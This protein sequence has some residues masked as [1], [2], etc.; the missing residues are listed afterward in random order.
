MGATNKGA[1]SK[2]V[3]AWEA[4]NDQSVKRAAGLGLMAV[5]LAACGSSDDSDDGDDGTDTTPV[6]M[7]A[8]LTIGQDLI[9]AGT[10]TGE[11][12]D[13]ITGAMLQGNGGVTAQSFEDADEIDGGDG[14]DTLT[15][16]IDD[17]VAAM[18]SNVETF[19]VR[20]VSSAV[21]TVDMANFDD[22]LETIT[23]RDSSVGVTIDNIQSAASIALDNVTGNVVVTVA[24]DDDVLGSDEAIA[25]LTVDGSTATVIADVGGE[26]VLTGAIIEVVSDS[27][28]TLSADAASNLETVE[29]VVITGAGDLSLIDAG[30]EFLAITEVDAS[31]LAGGLTMD[32]TSATGPV[33]FTGG[34]GDDDVTASGGA[35]EI[36]TGAGDDTITM[37]A[38]DLTIDAGAG[39]DTVEM[40]G[41]DDADTIDGGAGTN[42][43]SISGANLAAL[44]T[45]IVTDANV[46]NFSVVA[47]TAAMGADVTFNALGTGID[48]FDLTVAAGIAGDDLTLSN[49]NGGTIQFGVNQTG[50]VIVSDVGATDSITLVMDEGAGAT[51]ADV[52]VTSIETVLIV[53]D[54][55]ADDVV[56]TDIDLTGTTSLTISGAGD[57]TFTA[58]TTTALETVDL[59]DA[60]GAITID[61][62]GSDGVEVIVGNVG[63]ST[64]TLDAANVTTD[65]I[66][67]VGGEL[68][69][70]V[71]IDNFEAGI[72]GDVVD[73]SAFGVTGLADLTFTDAGADTTIEI[74]GIDG[75]I[76][77]GGVAAPADLDATNFIFA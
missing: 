45:A 69:N 39:D 66:T 34:S 56:F 74:D 8:A 7:S 29:T 57:V 76:T 75:I 70:D 10:D 23:V 36:S 1:V 27:A 47:V 13:T 73:L 59:S 9:E 35:D 12:D 53:T 44:R 48:T 14:D 28:I 2:L 38:G 52:D 65:T 3:K 24:Y 11:G 22:S 46:T 37:A 5:S 58:E 41:L 19:I 30:T 6:S 33:I 50:G 71:T 25:L 31:D 17:D 26:D 32:L 43:A 18:V 15:V 51:H 77:L 67:F 20:S 64:I 63:A 72:A 4:K 16:T 21:E 68:D 61:V 42:T 60:T 40:T 55:A 54:S 62:T 49:F